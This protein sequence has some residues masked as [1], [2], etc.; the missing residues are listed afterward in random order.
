MFNEATLIGR[1]GKD[2]ELRYTQN[3]TPVGSLW[4]ATSEVTNKDGNK[5]EHTEWHSV[6][7]WNKTAEHCKQYL[8]KGSLVFVKGRITHREYTDSRD[9]QKK[10]QTEIVAHTVKFLTPRQDGQ[11]SQNQIGENEAQNQN[12]TQGSDQFSGEFDSI[13]F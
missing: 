13:P 11:Q 7:V 8:K 4:M 1:L 12:T 5:Q 3:Q 9:G 10:K 2:P 6:V